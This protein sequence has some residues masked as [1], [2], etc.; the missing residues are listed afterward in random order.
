LITAVHALVLKGDTPP[1]MM[2]YPRDEHDMIAEVAPIAEE[3]STRK[4]RRAK[5]DEPYL[6]INAFMR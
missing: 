3:S 6:W 2:I 5:N 4:G 1:K